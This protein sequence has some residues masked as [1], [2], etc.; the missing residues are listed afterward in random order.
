MTSKI[1]INPEEWMCVDVCMREIRKKRGGTEGRREI[2]GKKV[3]NNLQA[4]RTI[5]GWRT[6]INL[7]N[8]Y[9]FIIFG[10]KESF[11]NRA[12]RV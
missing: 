5:N 11:D 10:G 6:W 9:L 12:L 1:E 3:V 4:C 7:F 2:F 8:R